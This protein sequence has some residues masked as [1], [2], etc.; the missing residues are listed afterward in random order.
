MTGP[1]RA[2]DKIDL[3]DRLE[4]SRQNRDR[5]GV[6][7]SVFRVRETPGYLVYSR[8]PCQSAGDD[9]QKTRRLGVVRLSAMS[10][11]SDFEFT[12][13]QSARNLCPQSSF[14]SQ[15]TSRGQGM[16]HD[17]EPDATVIL[18][19]LVL[20]LVG[21]TNDQ[22]TQPNAESMNMSICVLAI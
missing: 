1:S 10:R 4:Q 5:S 19:G 14:L 22:Q 11:W 6:D 21:R 15:I 9:Q 3:P 18:F 7:G 13:I 16:V 8:A 2:S 20:L 17:F 12:S